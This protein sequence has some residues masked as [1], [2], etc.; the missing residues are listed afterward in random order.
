ML[1]VLFDNNHAPIIILVCGIF[2]S[3]DNIIL[4]LFE[5]WQNEERFLLQKEYFWCTTEEVL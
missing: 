4:E 1:I 5:L 2:F 3:I